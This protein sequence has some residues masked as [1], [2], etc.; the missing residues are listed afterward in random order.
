MKNFTL[1]I[2]ILMIVF[3]SSIS[4]FAQVK[5]QSK[6]ITTSPAD[7]IANEEGKESL[8]DN[9]PVVS[10]DEAD[11]QD[12]SA[13][14]ISGYLNLGRNPFIT[15]SMYNFGVVRFRARG[16]DAD[17]SE[18]YINGAPMEN[19]DNGFTPYGLWGG[20]NDVLHRKESSYGLQ[21]NRFSFGS[22]GG[23]TSIDARAFKQYKQ[24]SI[25][26]SN[27]NR[28]YVH[29]FSLTKS[30]GFN[31]KGWA[32]SVSGSRRW[33]EEGFTDGTFYDGWSGFV[34]IDKQIN[35]NH[36]ISF[37]GF[38]TP[39][40]MGRQGSSV[41]EM[42]D[43]AGTNYYNP[44]WGFQNGKK[45]NSSIAKTTQPLGIL[46]DEWKITPK[47]TLTT[48][49]SLMSG[50]RSVTGLDWYNAADPRPDY[51]R[52]LPSYQE[53][54]TLRQRVFDELKND[55]TKRQINWDALYNSNKMS[56]ETIKNANGIAGN[57]VTGKRS[58][59]VVEERVINTTKY[60]FNTTF[61][62]TINSHVDIT[63]G[64]KHESQKNS[65][66]K[67][68]NDLLGGDFY[69]DLNQ[70]A[71]R[72]FPTDSIA[73]QNDANNPNRI[74][75]V[76]DKYGYNY[77]INIK[78]TSAWVQTNVKLK[79]LDFFV[80]GEGSSTSFWRVGNVKSGLFLN[81][82]YGKSVEQQFSNYAL[83]AG[84]SFKLAKMNYLYIN[85]RYE[86]RAPFFDNAYLA[87]R[88]RDY[89][90]DDLK[91]ESIGSVEAGYAL[92]APEVKLRATGYYTSIKNQTNVL[93]FYNDEMRTFVNYALSNI[94]KE[95]MGLELGAEVIIGK[96]FTTTAAAAIGQYTYSTRQ[97][98]TI[99]ADNT[100]ALLA[101]DEIIY[102]KNYRVPTPQQAYNVGLN[103]RSTKYWFVNLNFNY[104]DDM[105]LDY[106][107][108]RRTENAVSGIDPTSSLWGEILGQTRLKPQF[109]MDFFG[110]KSWLMNNKFKSL[111]KRTF[112]VLSLGINNITNNTSVTSGGYEQLRFDIAGKDL[113]K[114][115]SK[116]FYSYGTNFSA[117]IALRF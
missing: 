70:Y 80:G 100:S 63:A 88:T 38:A 82:S 27:S 47:S 64:F 29:R 114:F 5:T 111:G 97:L 14:N 46:S 19:L 93:T 117:N 61:A 50:N 104:F 81:N 4:V 89:I 60:N 69:V 91:N 68:V 45:R 23:S 101:K 24:T 83:K 79:A 51:Y 109:T 102:C 21:S 86:T 94:G 113:E 7:T 17:M 65:Y 58:V 73:G 40:T 78:R 116:R 1:A 30:T 103:Y 39:T 48:S 28:N 108:V 85:G 37:V 16:Y 62:T 10:L 34:G 95:Q 2:T 35:P 115:P 75:H 112:L 76:G 52:Y 15:A 92:I 106:N 31:S 32:Y 12:G 26:Y 105:W 66:Y 98:A 67:K 8:L 3:C 107:P 36:I 77:D 44:Y 57:N 99:T 20:L 42:L 18:T 53:D 22:M 11:D 6:P 84:T 41:Q 43:L 9:I 87:P 110:G 59:Y 25:G 90:Q 13:Q 33:A 56:I 54:E 49:I 74:L 96:G 72:D 55:I 71:E